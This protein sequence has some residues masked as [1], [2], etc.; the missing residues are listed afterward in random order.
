M[1]IYIYTHDRSYLNKMSAMGLQ[2]CEGTQITTTLLQKSP[3][4]VGLFRK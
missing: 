4:C 1:H 2:R 3:I